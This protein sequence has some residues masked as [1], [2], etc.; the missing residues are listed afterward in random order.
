MNLYYIT[1]MKLKLAEVSFYLEQLNTAND[2]INSFEYPLTSKAILDLIK[3]LK[4]EKKKL[5]K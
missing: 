2:I 4:T 5:N 1:S 3:K